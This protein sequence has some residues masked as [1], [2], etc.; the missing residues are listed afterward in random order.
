MKKLQSN[1]KMLNVFQNIVANINS[2]NK[3]H[4]NEEFQTTLMYAGMK[5]AYQNALLEVCIFGGLFELAPA[6]LNKFG[7]NL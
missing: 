1:T 4:E 5:L 2:V 7:C 3:L 6:K